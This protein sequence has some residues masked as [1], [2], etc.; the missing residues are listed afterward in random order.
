MSS[1]MTNLALNWLINNVKEKKEKSD[2][3]T[4]PNA[5]THVYRTN[6]SFTYFWD[7]VSLA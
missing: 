2:E 5:I 7:H 4:Y 6:A 3:P 1:S